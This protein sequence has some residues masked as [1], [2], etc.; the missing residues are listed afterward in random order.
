M[1]NGNKT[2]GILI[3]GNYIQTFVGIPI[4]IRVLIN[5]IIKFKK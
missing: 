1:I 3:L 4:L 5:L 2:G